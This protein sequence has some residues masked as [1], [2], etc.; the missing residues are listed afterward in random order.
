MS[1]EQL[2]A[3]ANREAR[4]TWNLPGG[5]AMP[6]AIADA[7]VRVAE[8]YAEEILRMHD[9]DLTE[10]NRVRVVMREVA[11]ELRAWATRE[12][13]DDN[14]CELNS[15]AERLLIAANGETKTDPH[16]CG[17]VD[18]ETCWRAGCDHD[19]PAPVAQAKCTPEQWLRGGD[20]GLSSETICRLLGNLGP[21]RSPS[22]PL[23][24]G[25]FGRCYRLLK[26]FPEWRARMPEVAAKYPATVWPAYV[27]KW[28]R[29]TALFEAGK[30]DE[31]YRLMCD[32]RGLPHTSEATKEPDR[33]KWEPPPSEVLDAL[34]QRQAAIQT[35]SGEAA[36]D[37]PRMIPGDGRK[38]C[39]TM[40]RQI[41]KL[42]QER[43]RAE[44]AANTWQMQYEE[45]GEV[46]SCQLR[47][48]TQERDAARAEAE[49]AWQAIPHRGAMRGMVPLAEVLR[50]LYEDRET[51]R[52]E[53]DQLRATLAKI[54]EVLGVE[55]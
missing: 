24:S 6:P 26:M 42:V 2:R 5:I 14:E 19:A 7:I 48:L 44:A 33:I 49:A 11:A 35:L 45:Q 29:M 28:D 18:G 13:D 55:R 46:L 8:K 40:Q 20:T 36:K 47:T 4:A 3:E 53:V 41:D 37:E 21:P 12:T 17:Y 39:Q 31:L 43:D 54:R 15:K 23:D 38:C 50:D 32:L 22:H 30:R 16:V 1:P 10:L 9:D 27:A 34:H 25:D 51:N 52:A